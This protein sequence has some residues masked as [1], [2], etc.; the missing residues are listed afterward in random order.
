MGFSFFRSSKTQ[1]RRRDKKLF[2]PL[3]TYARNLGLDS[4]T[5]SELYH[6]KESQRIPFLLLDRNRGIYLID[7]A[8]W[9]LDDLLNV[10]AEQAPRNIDQSKDVD[11]DSANRMIA[12][13]LDE[14]LNTETCAL[15]NF[16]YLPYLSSSDFDTLDES[17]RAL[18]PKSRVIFADEDETAIALKLSKALSLRK[19]PYEPSSIAGALFI[20]YTLHP[21]QRNPVPKRLTPQQQDYVDAAPVKRSILRG[22]YGS[23]KS[24]ALLLK[25]LYHKLQYP[26]E[27]VLI[28]QPTVAAAE[29][30]TRTLLEFIEYAVV[31]IDPTSLRIASAQQICREHHTKVHHKPPLIDGNISEKMFSKK[32]K[33]ADVLFIDDADLLDERYMEYFRHLQQHKGLHLAVT[34]NAFEEGE[35][36]RLAHSFVQ[37]YSLTRYHQKG[38]DASA[39]ISFYEGDAFI[40]TLH[41][42]QQ[43]LQKHN[44]EDFLIIVPDESFAERL[45]EEVTDFIGGDLTLFDPH[46]TLLNQNMEQLLIAPMGGLSGLSRKQLIIICDDETEAHK[47]SHAIGRAEEEATIIYHTSE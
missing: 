35:V 39:P 25:A 15:C 45:Y 1:D 31:H 46:K 22:T 8:P 21:D 29:M 43:R 17:F 41:L 24:S 18:I 16:L 30:M 4:Y 12:L 3:E 32:E 33:L 10:K 42:L 27:E 13:K 40:L 47:L 36:Y 5:D 23:G 28:L 34:S 2:I 19:T 44:A 38:K 11:V 26:E 7:T 14:I 37:P 6:H 9:K 20:Q